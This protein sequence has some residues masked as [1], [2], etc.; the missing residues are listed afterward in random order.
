M[1]IL[2]AFTL[3]MVAVGIV[4]HTMPHSFSVLEVALKTVL[5]IGKVAIKVV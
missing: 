4:P 5:T 3:K 2:I 1:P